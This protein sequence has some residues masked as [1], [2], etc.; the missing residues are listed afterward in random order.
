MSSILANS[1]F[2]SSAPLLPA[3]V[4]GLLPAEQIQ[5]PP[6]PIS[7]ERSAERGKHF[8][9]FSAAVCSSKYALGDFKLT[10]SAAFPLVIM[11][12]HPPLLL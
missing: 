10:P 11:S 3:C 6:A 7:L 8:S 5:P 9:G 1:P 2:E 4:S 12:H